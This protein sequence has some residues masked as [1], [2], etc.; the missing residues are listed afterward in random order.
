VKNTRS[1]T[2]RKEGRDLG[3]TPTERHQKNQLMRQFIR[4][5][6]EKG[7]SQAFKEGWDRIFGKSADE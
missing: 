6:G 7:N 3:L 1:A 5:D 4:G 2:I